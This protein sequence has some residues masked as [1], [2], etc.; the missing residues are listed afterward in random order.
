M[1][2]TWEVDAV[3]QA[4]DGSP[5]ADSKSD[6]LGAIRLTR[7]ILNTLVCPTSVASIGAWYPEQSVSVL[8]DL[9]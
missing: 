9:S 7:W 5:V 1:G 2:N 6:T 3:V 8:V 4:D